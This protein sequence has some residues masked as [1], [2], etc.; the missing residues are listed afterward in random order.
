VDQFVGSYYEKFK[1]GYLRVVLVL[2]LLCVAHTEQRYSC[3]I[4]AEYV[5]CGRDRGALQLFVLLLNLL[6]GTDRAA[7]QLFLLVLSLLCVAQTEQHYNCFI[8][9][10]F[11]MCG[12][13]R[14]ALQLFILVLRLLCVAQTEQH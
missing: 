9:V 12:T 5:M 1:C 10:D 11:V 6:S 7:L 13:N 3:F 8:S 4:S 14:A 2:N